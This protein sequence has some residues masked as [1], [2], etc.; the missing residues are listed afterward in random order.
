MSIF[1][2]LYP[3]VSAWCLEVSNSIHLC[4]LISISVH[5]YLFWCSLFVYYLSFIYLYCLSIIYYLF[6]CYM[7]IFIYLVKLCQLVSICVHQY[8]PLSIYVHHSPLVFT[9]VHLCLVVYICAKLCTFWLSV[10]P[11]V[12]ESVSPWVKFNFIELLTQLKTLQ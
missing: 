1:F 6:I 10:S 3:L 8:P 2:Q 4:T 11:W 5:F 9:F 7:F 12:P